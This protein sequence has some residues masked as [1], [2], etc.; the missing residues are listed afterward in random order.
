[1]DLGES[2]GGFMAG[3]LINSGQN[4]ATPGNCIARWAIDAKLL[5]TLLRWG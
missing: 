5:N 1:M 4:T 2:F 3:E